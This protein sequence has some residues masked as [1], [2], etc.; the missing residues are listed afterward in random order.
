MD[1]DEDEF[2]GG[3]VYFQGQRVSCAEEEKDKNVNQMVT[4]LPDQVVYANHAKAFPYQITFQGVIMFLDISGFTALTEQYSMNKRN[5]TD[6][7]TKTLNGYFHALC[8]EVIGHDGDILKFAGARP[9]LTYLLCFFC[10]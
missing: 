2:Y 5:G 3:D 6:Q 1:S 10:D 7:L 8:S 4:H 9:C